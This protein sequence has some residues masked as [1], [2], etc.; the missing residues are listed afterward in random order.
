MIILGWALF[1]WGDCWTLSGRT[2]QDIPPYAYKYI[3]SESPRP[4]GWHTVRR[5]RKCGPFLV[6]RLRPR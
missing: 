4:S 1:G 3:T 6:T 5:L 2:A